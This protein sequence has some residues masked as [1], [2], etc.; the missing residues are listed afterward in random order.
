MY[1]MLLALTLVLQI[2]CGDSKPDTGGGSVDADA[3]TDTDTDTGDVVDTGESSGSDTG[4]PDEE[5]SSSDTGRGPAIGGESDSGLMGEDELSDQL[6]GKLTTCGGC[7]TGN[8][9]HGWWVLGLL[10]L[11]RRRSS[12]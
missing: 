8:Q 4:D 11:L 6:T 3:D 5:E 1:R 2:S 10:G 9:T 7:S 12:G